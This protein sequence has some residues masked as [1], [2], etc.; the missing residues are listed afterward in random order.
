MIRWRRLSVI[1]MLLIIVML[2]I[3]P[4]RRINAASGPVVTFTT[5]AQVNPQKVQFVTENDTDQNA[6]ITLRLPSSLIADTGDETTASLSWH[7]QLTQTTLTLSAHQTQRW[8]IAVKTLTPGAG[9]IQVFDSQQHQLAV[10]EISVMSTQSANATTSSDS[11]ETSTTAKSESQTGVKGSEVNSNKDQSHVQLPPTETAGA[12]T[13]STGTLT[14]SSS[15]SSLK[16]VQDD[17]AKSKNAAN[18]DKSSVQQSTTQTSTASSST[19][20]QSTPQPSDHHAKTSSQT[21]AVDDNRAPV[22]D[23]GDPL[24]GNYVHYTGGSL[25]LPIFL[26]VPTA[27]RYLVYLELWSGKYQAVDEVTVATATNRQ[28]ITVTIPAQYMPQYSDQLSGFNIRIGDESNNFSD[29]L[30]YV[31]SLDVPNKPATTLSIA[32]PHTVTFNPTDEPLDAEKVWGQKLPARILPV[33]SDEIGANTLSVVDNREG[34]RSW[35]LTVSADQSQ[36]LS[37]PERD[38]LQDAMH[39]VRQGRDLPVNNHQVLVAT[40]GDYPSEVIHDVDYHLYTAVTNIS[41][42]WDAQTGLFL[43][44]PTGTEGGEAYSGSVTWHVTDGVANN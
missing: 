41:Q 44:V 15:I 18:F 38:V 19:Q 23:Y 24:A 31:L 43:E 37:D 29:P 26:T 10:Q 30:H 35:T 40:Q 27:G 17:E 36:Q 8:T 20:A 9:A 25:A 13:L 5:G 4:S 34:T 3:T 11:D 42:H 12:G 14:G 28:K 6:T 2:F 7:E 32:A 1:S 33:N 16:V 22:I 21:R 39:Y